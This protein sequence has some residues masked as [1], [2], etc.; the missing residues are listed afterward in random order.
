[1]KWLLDTNVVSE[2][3]RARPNLRVMNWL[4]SQPRKDLAVSAVT[5]AELRDGVATAANPARQNALTRWLETDASRYLDKQTIEVTVE[6]LVEW[7]ALSRKLRSGGTSRDAADIL[8]ASTARVHDLPL[9][10]RNVRDFAD[11]GIVVYD[12][13]N[14]QTHRM[15]PP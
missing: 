2:G 10:T 11:T 15:D 9:V 14:D 13:W 5:M 1:M 12:P 3:V 8:I 4:S 7:I 6:I